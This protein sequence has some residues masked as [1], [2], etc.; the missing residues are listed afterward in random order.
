[1]KSGKV[2][3]D[4]LY[5][6]PNPPKCQPFFDFSLQIGKYRKFGKY[7]LS[8]CPTCVSAK[9]TKSKSF[10]SCKKSGSWLLSNDFGLISPMF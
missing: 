7:I 8:P 6:I 3:R 4:G 10:I 2:L 9:N 5:R 1:M